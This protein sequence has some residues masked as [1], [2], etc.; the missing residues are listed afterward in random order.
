MVKPSGREPVY[1]RI[2][3]YQEDKIKKLFKLKP[4]PKSF[5]VGENTI[6]T[7]DVLGFTDDK[8]KGTLGITNIEQLKEHIRQ[9]DWYK[10]NSKRKK[11]NQVSV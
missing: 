9:Q 5:L 10:R 3:H 2:T 1:H 8:P 4:R 11:L 6:V 7:Q